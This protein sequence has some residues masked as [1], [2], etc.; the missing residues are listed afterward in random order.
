MIN[1]LKTVTSNSNSFQHFRILN[2]SK[3]RQIETVQIQIT[4]QHTFQ[5][6]TTFQTYTILKCARYQIKILFTT[7][8]RHCRANFPSSYLRITGKS[9][10]T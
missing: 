8:A 2:I 4:F 10:P 9:I 6:F 7:Q 1:T 5:N 3:R